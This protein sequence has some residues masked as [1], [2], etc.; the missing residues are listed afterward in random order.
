M[1][2]PVLHGQ[3][4]WA[5]R[6][7]NKPHLASLAGAVRDLVRV[8]TLEL[9]FIA[10]DALG[11]LLDHVTTAIQAAA[12]D[13]VAVGISC[14]TSLHYLGTQAVARHVRALAPDLPIIIGGHHA[15]ALSSDFDIATCDFLVR[16]DGEHALRRLLSPASTTSTTTSETLTRPTTMQVIDGGVFDQSDITHIDWDRY[17]RPGMRPRALWLGTSR[18]CA[19][20]CRFCIEP[21]R[22]ARYSRYEVTPL[23]DVIERLVE[24]H[25]PRVIAFS[26][27]LFGHNRS[28][29]EAF[30]DGLEQRDLPLMFWC[31]TRADLMTPEILERF[32]RLDFMVD[33]G[34]DTASLAMIRMMGK[35]A[36]P[37]NYLDRARATFEA[38][39]KLGLHHG[40]YLIFNYPGETPETAAETQAWIDSLVSDA[41]G[42][43]GT[44]SGW[45]SAQT[46]FVLPGTESYARMADNAL[47]HGTHVANPDWWR[48]EGSHY[49]L[50]TD[51]VPSAAWR[52][53]EAEL[54][55]FRAWNQSVNRTWSSR[56]P[57]EVAAFRARFYMG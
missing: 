13:L 51:V 5:N 24:T 17:G 10:G 4:W 38:A 19:F 9:D 3:D 11:P 23:V 40:I 26:D 55:A 2:P 25:G 34:L 27:P 21:E 1:S 36:Q 32:R 14:W 37:Q 16:G 44:M 29:L 6:I 49:Q 30:L 52:G 12:G 45:L 7:A 39:N 35:A 15:T 18:G 41:S 53:R 50:A 8:V 33:F 20:K 43:G 47:R 57:P 54:G 46:F 28:W 42:P 48:R 31:E 22:G 56:Y